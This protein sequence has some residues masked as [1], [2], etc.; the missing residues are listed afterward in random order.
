MPHYTIDKKFLDMLIMLIHL[1]NQQLAK[2]ISE[3]ENIPYHLVL[4]YVPSTHKV[5]TLIGRHD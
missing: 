3:E 4:Q 1:Q 2:I 5:K